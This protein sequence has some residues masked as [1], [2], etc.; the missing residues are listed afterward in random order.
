M[1]ELAVVGRLGRFAQ[2]TLGHAAV[3]ECQR[4]G[5]SET[6]RRIRLDGVERWHGLTL[7]L[8]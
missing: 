3:G 4:S 2:G 6:Q 7:P 5:H 8:A 1:P